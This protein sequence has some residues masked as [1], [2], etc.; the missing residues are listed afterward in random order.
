MTEQNRRLAVGKEA[1]LSAV[2]CCEMLVALHDIK[3]MQEQN[4]QFTSVF[5]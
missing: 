3:E 5:F 2:Q 1:S 4:S